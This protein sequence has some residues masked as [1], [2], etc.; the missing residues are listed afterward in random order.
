MGAGSL[1]NAIRFMAMGERYVPVEFMQAKEDEVNPL[2][3][4]F[5]RELKFLM[6]WA[7]AL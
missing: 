4:K 5:D 1:V 7:A 6:G 3:D 2:A